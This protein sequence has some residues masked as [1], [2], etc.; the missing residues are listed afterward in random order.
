MNKIAYYFEHPEFFWLLP[1][2][3]TAGLASRV[4]LA[5]KR[6]AVRLLGQAAAVHKLMRIDP[7]KRRLRGLCLALGLLLLLIASAGPR[8]AGAF[9]PKP[10]RDTTW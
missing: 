10:K 5:A 2:L 9:P 7:G 1:V 6:R 3:A 8:W 4:E